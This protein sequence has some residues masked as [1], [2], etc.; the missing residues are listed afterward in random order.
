MK[1]TL[2]IAALAFLL[3]A[4]L[5]TVSLADTQTFILPARGVITDANAAAASAA[6]LSV[7]GVVSAE[8]FVGTHTI[9]V[10]VL[11]QSIPIEEVIRAINAAGYTVGKPRLKG[12]DRK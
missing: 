11:D 10:E 9:E 1:E 8:A 6:A 7:K 5:A 12:P 2:C 3:T 4:S